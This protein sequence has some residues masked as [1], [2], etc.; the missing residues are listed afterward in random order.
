MTLNKL[1]TWRVLII[2]DHKDIGYI[3]EKIP[4]RTTFK[5]AYMIKN[6]ILKGIRDKG[7]MTSRIRL[8]RVK[9]V[10]QLE[11]NNVETL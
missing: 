10:L 8:E 7:D 5:Q 4:F 1:Y 2:D 11:I 6:K 3:L 9:P